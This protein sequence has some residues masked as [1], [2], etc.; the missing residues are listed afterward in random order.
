VNGIA[1]AGEFV[2]LSSAGLVIP[3]ETVL[4]AGTQQ[5]S[6][7]FMPFDGNYSNAVKSVTITVVQPSGGLTFKGFYPPVRNMPVRNRVKAGRAVDVKFSVSGNRGASA[8]AAG[9]PTSRSV[10]CVAGAPEKTIEDGSDAR[11]SRLE[12]DRRRGQ[13]RYTWKT[14]SSWAGTCRV[15]EVKLVDGSMHEALFRFPQKQRGRNDR[16][17][18]GNGRDKDRDDRGDGRRDRE[19]DDDD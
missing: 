8:L 13:Y 14:I 9:W 5:L 15:L 1:L 6:V 4:Q 12:Y 11:R 19:R 2:Y 17:Y 3:G 10:P 18:R 16:E 7:E